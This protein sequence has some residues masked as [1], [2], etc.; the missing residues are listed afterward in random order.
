M[1]RKSQQQQDETRYCENCGISFIWT[2]EEQRANALGRS[3]PGDEDA[4]GDAEAQPA[5]LVS[6][7]PPKRCLGCRYLLPPEGRERGL[8]KWYHR[9]KGYGFITRNGSP[10]LYVNRSALRRGHLMPGE[11]VEFSLGH[12]PQGLAATHVTV[13]AGDSTA[14]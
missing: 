14:Y 11:L 4:A 12:S 2:V 3:E 7:A 9:R 1:A 6:I 8:V 10:D 13:V 5:G